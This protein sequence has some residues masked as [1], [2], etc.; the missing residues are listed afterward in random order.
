MR[1]YQMGGTRERMAEG[2]RSKKSDRQ[3][4]EEKGV[5]HAT[6]KKNIGHDQR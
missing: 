3:E 4:E 2:E 6:F 5:S 1:E